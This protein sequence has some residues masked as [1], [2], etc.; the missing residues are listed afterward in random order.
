VRLHPP[1]RTGP[2][3]AITAAP[4]RVR[5]TADTQLSDRPPTGGFA[6]SL[7]LHVRQGRTR[8][9]MGTRA[10]PRRADGPLAARVTPPREPGRS[11]GFVRALRPVPAQVGWG[12]TPSILA[13][14]AQRRRT[15]A[16]SRPAGEGVWDPGREGRWE[17]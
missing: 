3:F 17:L 10:G 12:F 7:L 15:T 13:G 6:T 9:W 11:R 14:R 2:F 4:R 5:Q 8:I 16:S 1:C